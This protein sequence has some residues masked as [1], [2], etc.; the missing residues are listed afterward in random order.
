VFVHLATDGAPNSSY[1]LDMTPQT[2]SFSDDAFLDVGKTFTDPTSGVTITTLSVTSTT[3]TINVEMSSVCTR[4]APQVTASPGRSQDVPAETY[5]DVQHLRDQQRQRGVP[6]D[7]L[8]A[9]GYNARQWVAEDLRASSLAAGPGAT[10]STTLWVTS[11]TVPTGS[12]T[13]VGAA[14]NGALTSLSGSAAMVYAVVP[15]GGPIG[16]GPS[17]MASIGLTSRPST[18]GG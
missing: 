5:R 16:A 7:E 8:R 17:R 4:S 3:A 2:P 11:P 1:L 15:A 13:I 9:P 10:V 18:T 14:V 12:Y 6:G